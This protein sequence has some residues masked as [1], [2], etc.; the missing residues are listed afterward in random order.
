MTKVGGLDHA[1]ETRFND[2]D[3]CLRAAKVGIRSYI[4][5]ETLAFHF[6]SKTLNKMAISEEEKAKRLFI[7]M[8]STLE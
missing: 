1:L 3:F 4:V 2:H 5:F 6:G 8:K 7:S